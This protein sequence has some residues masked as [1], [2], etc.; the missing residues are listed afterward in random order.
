MIPLE[1][2]FSWFC[3]VEA[4]T[5]LKLKSEQKI[6]E[7]LG[8][9]IKRLQVRLCPLLPWRRGRHA[10]V[11]TPGQTRLG[12][13]RQGSPCLL[14]CHSCDML[15]PRRRVR[16]FIFLFYPSAAVDEPRGRR[17]IL[18]IHPDACLLQLRVPTAVPQL[19]K[20]V[21]GLV[22]ILPQFESFYPFPI[23]S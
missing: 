19:A 17:G 7:F 5:K 10:G 6:V 8:D 15:I 23:F 13:R 1:K 14:R 3:L 4:Q 16:Q 21:V 11:D 9:R 18:V 12:R 22:R 20:A 2:F